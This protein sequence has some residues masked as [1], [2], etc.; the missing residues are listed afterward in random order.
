MKVH[1]GPFFSPPSNLVK[2]PL[3]GDNQDNFFWRWVDMIELNGKE[4][5]FPVGVAVDVLSG[6]R[7]LM[8]TQ[9]FKAL[10][11][12]RCLQ[13]PFTRNCRPV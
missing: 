3:F 8:L 5:R 10:E 11:W 7:S 2:L 13:G 4:Y 6:Q 1:E 9:Q 12:D